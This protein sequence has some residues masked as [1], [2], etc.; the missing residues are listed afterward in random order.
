MSRALGGTLGTSVAATATKPGYLIE[1]VLSTTYRFSTRGLIDW[2]G[3]LWSPGDVR[4]S[5]MA[6]DASQPTSS[7]SILIAA[8]MSWAS[9]AHSNTIPGAAIRVWQFYGD[10]DPAASETVLLFD[11]VGDSASINDAGAVTITL[12]QAGGAT[13]YL[14]RTY[15]TTA[16]GFNHLPKD[17]QLVTFNGETVRLMP[18]GV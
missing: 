6:V 17:G 9:I 5:G 7:A 4:V 18:D 15:M 10:T 11:G 2:D 14:P 8:T 16:N 3:S 13:L 1:I 12:T